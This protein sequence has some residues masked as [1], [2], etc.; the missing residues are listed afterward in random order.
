MTP[1][2]KR[3]QDDP[4]E[5]MPTPDTSPPQPEEGGSGPVTLPRTR[6]GVTGDGAPAISIGE[7]GSLEV[8]AAIPPAAE[9]A[10]SDDFLPNR[11]EEAVIARD[12]SRTGSRFDEV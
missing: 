7:E 1:Q 8:D 9:D 3:R 11:R 2:E 12:P 5:P 6:P 4:V 10:E